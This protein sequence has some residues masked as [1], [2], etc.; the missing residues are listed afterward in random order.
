MANAP[1]RSINVYAT[2]NGKKIEVSELEISNRV[3]ALATARIT[4]HNAEDAKATQQSAEISLSKFANQ[5]G[6][7]QNYVLTA[8][9]LDPDFLVSVVDGQGGSLNFKGSLSAPAFSVGY[10]SANMSYS[11]VHEAAILG[12]YHGEAFTQAGFGLDFMGESARDAYRTLA[13]DPGNW[14][15]F[16]GSVAEQMLTQLTSAKRT[17]A[18]IGS[19][20]P[21][22][23]DTSRAIA[24]AMH[25]TNNVV[26][27][28]V[29][30]FLQGSVETTRIPGV[31]GFGEDLDLAIR[32]HLWASLTSEGGL[33][34]VLLNVIPVEYGMQ[35]VCS[36]TG[37]SPAARLELLSY[38]N[39]EPTP[40]TIA[41]ENFSFVSGGELA[42]PIRAV[43]VRGAKN[44]DEM[45][46]PQGADSPNQF[47]TAVACY[48]STATI[49]PGSRVVVRDAPAWFNSGNVA[50]ISDP[51]TYKGP[52]DI[53][54]YRAQHPRLSKLIA[55]LNNDA[56]RLLTW[57]AKTQFSYLSLVSSQASA[58]LP[59][60]AGIQVGRVYTIRVYDSS[61]SASQLF[62]GYVESVSHHIGVQEGG[63]DASTSISFSHVQASGYTQVGDRPKL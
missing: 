41:A 25:E 42:L 1:V 27:S 63:L 36:L 11:G 32:N 46:A 16:T 26:W 24:F 30:A 54:A 21:N 45:T 56:Q 22:D 35:F 3:G 52:G 2:V 43:V 34:G 10:G 61:G 20:S 13:Y 5:A 38:V 28:K 49:S 14:P 44:V 59:L 48:P 23:N 19:R 6:T 50:L 47:A 53:A 18:A 60:T 8:K 17:L 7:L 9:R 31:T 37:Q 51:T 40:L 4:G 15:P 58:K 12:F 29:Q 39:A 55:N 62:T 57:W 33:L